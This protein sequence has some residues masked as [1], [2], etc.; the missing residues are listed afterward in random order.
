MTSGRKLA[1]LVRDLATLCPCRLEQDG[2]PLTPDLPAGV[3]RCELDARGT[4]WLAVAGWPEPL[5]VLGF[6]CDGPEQVALAGAP[7]LA[8]RFLGE[9]EG[10]PPEGLSPDASRRFYDLRLAAL[11]AR[12][13]PRGL[14][15]ESVASGPDARQRVP[16]LFARLVFR[17]P[18]GFAA[19]L[20]LYPFQGAGAGSAFLTAALVWLEHCR[21]TRRRFDR[22]LA[23]CLHG[24][25]AL[26]LLGRLELLDPAQ[27]QTRL[28]RYDL[29][30]GAVEEIDA[31]EIRR[32]CRLPVSFEFA[33]ER[34][35]FDN[36]LARELVAAFPGDL[37][38]EKTPYAFDVVSC[39][40]L[41]LVRVGGG[42]PGDLLMGWEPPL[43]AWSDLGRERALA[44]VGQAV[45]LRSDPPLV[46]GH[47]AYRLFPERWL[48]RLLLDDIGVLDPA[49]QGAWTYRQV[50]TYRGT[51]RS[52][53]DVL[54]LDAANRLVVVEIK[55]AECGTLLFQ[56]L[57]YW[58]RV[59]DGLRSGAFGRCGYFAGVRL[60]PEPP[61][62]V[63]VT[64]LF[65]C[66][67]QQRALAGYLRPGL[68]VR[69]VECNLRWR[70]GLRIV[71]RTAL[72][73]GPGAVADG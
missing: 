24:D 34:P 72:G 46:P 19:G 15:L 29:A 32:R 37:R 47:A 57:D 49:F 7:G 8:L 38:H 64:P 54:T 51:G 6:G 20:G 3:C 45:R 17:R 60:S 13:P 69:L 66:H 59:A 43:R 40:G 71:R 31:A 28:F 11:L 63:L 9:A 33:P 16:G 27:V 58:E 44:L 55:A 1:G 61:A 18:G 25:A 36:A 50:P 73:A 2:V 42:G 39:R 5:R 48:E 14:A 67:R 56:A 26:H 62:L 53:M 70:R 68:D 10:A 12:R 65:R 4:P 21:G 30:V 52:I 22:T 23:L 41:P 35:C